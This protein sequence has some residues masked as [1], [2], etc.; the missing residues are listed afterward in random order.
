MTYYP[1]V[2]L[3]EEIVKKI[4]SLGGLDKQIH[5]V[6]FIIQD[7]MNSELPTFH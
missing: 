5:N 6:D 1:F 4:V 7:F 2:T 3:F